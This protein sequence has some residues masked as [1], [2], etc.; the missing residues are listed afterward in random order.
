MLSRTWLRIP[1]D[2]HLGVIVFLWTQAL[3]DLD[4]HSLGR[5]GLVPVGHE[6]YLGEYQEVVWFTFEYFVP[7]SW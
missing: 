1:G 3:N 6:E 7:I 5:E 2:C 4:C